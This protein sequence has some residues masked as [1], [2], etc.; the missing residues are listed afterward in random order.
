MKVGCGPIVVLLVLLSGGSPA[1]PEPTGL[2]ATDTPP[3]GV[4]APAALMVTWYCSS[5]SPCTVGH[6]ANCLCA[7]ASRDLHWR[8]ERVRVTYQHRSV[9]VRIIDCLCSRSGGLDLYAAAFSQLAPLSRGVIY[10]HAE[11]LRN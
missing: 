4:A 6:P 9:V 7:A 3:V 11:R 5:T 10:A 1:M 8:G 2:P